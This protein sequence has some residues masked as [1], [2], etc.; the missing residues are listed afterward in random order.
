MAGATLPITGGAASPLTVDFAFAGSTQYG[1]D[2]GVTALSQN[3]STS[4]KLAGFN[5]A[6]DGIIRGRYTNGQTLNLGQVVLSTFVN[7]QGLNPLGSGQY[8]ETPRSGLAVTGAPGTGTLGSLQ[9]AALE[10]GNVDITEALVDLITAQRTYQANAQ[11]IK[12]NDAVLQTLVN[13]R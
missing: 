7:A 9:A 2:F 10:E 5:I 6:S 3:G 1:S 11:T 4:G 13:L 12:T 8:A